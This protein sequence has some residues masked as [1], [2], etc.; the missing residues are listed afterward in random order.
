MFGLQPPLQT[1]LHLIQ[2]VPLEM[3]E[4]KYQTMGT[5]SVLGHGLFNNQAQREDQLHYN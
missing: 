5:G 4:K 2:E 1:K 3:F